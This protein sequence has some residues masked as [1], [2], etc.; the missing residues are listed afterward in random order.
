M[1]AQYYRGHRHQEF[2]RFL[3]LTDAAVPKELNLEI[4]ETLAACCGLINDSRH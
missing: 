3:K 1:I 4:L 2:L